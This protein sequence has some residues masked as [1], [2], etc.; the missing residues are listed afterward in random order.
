MKRCSD[1]P[2]QRKCNKEV[3]GRLIFDLLPQKA[4]RGLFLPS[5][6]QIKSKKLKYSNFSLLLHTQNVLFMG[7]SDL[8]P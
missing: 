4:I 6:F 2:S 7:Q 1:F 8:D 5:K 3:T